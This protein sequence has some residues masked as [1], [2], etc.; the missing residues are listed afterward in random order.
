MRGKFNFT[1]K[2]TKIPGGGENPDNFLEVTCE[3]LAQFSEI[4]QDQTLEGRPLCV[5]TPPPEPEVVPE[6]V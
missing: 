5:I 2:F 4:S 1:L 6:P 3:S